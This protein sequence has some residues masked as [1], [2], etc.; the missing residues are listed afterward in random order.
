MEAQTIRRYLVSR[1]SGSLSIELEDEFGRQ[2]IIWHKL[3]KLLQ[4][5]GDNAI[6]L[7]AGVEDGVSFPETDSQ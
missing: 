3:R 5:S 7:P 2:T 4:S 6:V 1:E